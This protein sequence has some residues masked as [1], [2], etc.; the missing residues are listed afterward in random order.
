[1]RTKQGAM[2]VHCV[3]FLVLFCPMTVQPL[4]QVAVLGSGI[5]GSTV[6]RRLADSGQFEIT[7]FECG[8]GVGGRTSTRIT[9][10]GKYQF[11][12]GA[13]YISTPKTAAFRQELDSWIERGWVQ[14]WEGRFGTVDLSEGTVKVE[15]PGSKDRF[16]GKPRMCSICEN[17][18]DHDQ[19]TVHTQT[20]ACVQQTTTVCMGDKPK[21]IV[22]VESDNA[23]HDASNSHNE[24]DDFAISFGTFDWLVVSDRLSA[25]GAR[26]DLRQIPIGTFREFVN[27]ITNV[28]SLTLMVTL[29]EP[30]PIALDGIL[31]GS[32]RQTQDEDSWNTSIG[33]AARDSSKPGRMCSGSGECWVVQ[34]DTESAQKLIAEVSSRGMGFAETKAAVADEAKTML[35]NDFSETMGWLLHR[36]ENESVEE[37][38]SKKSMP[39]IVSAIGHRWGAAFPGGAATLT[40]TSE[41][42][43]D[44]MELLFNQNFVA[45]GDYFPQ[46]QPGRIEG[47][48]LSGHEAAR[49][50]LETLAVGGDNNGTD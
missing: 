1:M 28:P 43:A 50:I 2:W 36:I 5:A 27:R 32:S 16:V 38:E 4:Q 30:L 14:R 18:L 15:D 33:W 44:R 37:H 47:A 46:T 7:V 19:I 22:G 9:R 39:R 24:N 23:D 49:S 17:L 26:T 35:L 48:F 8:R 45:C 21:W 11:D 20:R 13:Q 42:N 31:F 29:E 6:A 25:T 12:H 40:T 41:A 3:A 34:S 10:D